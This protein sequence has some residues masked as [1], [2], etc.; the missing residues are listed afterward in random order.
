MSQ[1]VHSL[2]DVAAAAGVSYRWVRK[3]IADGRLA[4]V[5]LPVANA[6]QHSPRIVVTDAELRRFLAERRPASDV[7]TTQPISRRKRPEKGTTK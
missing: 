7:N 3:L 2:A 4:A 1:T 6:N 5:A